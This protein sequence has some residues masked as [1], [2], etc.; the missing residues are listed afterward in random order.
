M[1][2]FWGTS[3]QE[4]PTKNLAPELQD[5]LKKE[6]PSAYTTSVNPSKDIPA[7][8]SPFPSTPQTHN[9]QQPKSD[10]STTEDVPAVPAASLYQDG[11]YAHLWKT[12]KPLSEIEATMPMQSA[13]RVVEQFKQRKDSVHLAA[14]ENCA[15]EHEALTH[16]FSKGDWWSMV[17]ARATM[18]SDENRKF[19][20]CYTTQAVCLPFLTSSV[21]DFQKETEVLTAVKKFLQALGYAGSF[22]YDEEKEERIQLHADKLYHQMIDYEKQV[23][24]AR[25]AGTEPPPITSLFNPTA[26]PVSLSDDNDNT[27]V[28]GGEQLPEGYQLSK[29]LEK[30]SPHER[31]LEIQS[32]KAEIEQKKKY[33]QEAAPF[34]KTQQESRE[35]RQETATKWFG[36]TIGKWIT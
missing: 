34:V 12:Y 18:C 15:L 22:E 13:Q 20:R 14:M 16:C 2:W 7:S 23:A 9:T 32:I 26:K 17:K 24:E 29:P 11:R 6:T 27:L 31:E 28:P 33:S 5:Y 30:L 36:E 8:Q 1:G 21:S 3:N 4:D 25:A 19:S 10:S 35:K